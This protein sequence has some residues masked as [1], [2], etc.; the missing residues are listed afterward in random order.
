[1]IPA[2]GARR[3]VFAVTTVVVAA[4]LLVWLT[5]WLWQQDQVGADRANI[6][7]LPVAI[8]AALLAAV[9]TWFALKDRRPST[10]SIDVMHGL[11]R[12][13][14]KE[15]QRFIDQALGVHWYTDLADVT[16]ANPDAGKLPTGMETLLVNWQDV[17]G[18]RAG[19]VKDV[20]DFYRDETN[21]R[22]VILGPPGSG[23]SMVLSHLVCDLVDRLPE[24]ES[25]RPPH[26]WQVPIMISM[27]GCDLVD[28]GVVTDQ[29]LAERLNTW[30]AERLVDDYQIPLA[31]A[32]ALI[33]DQRILPVLDGLDEMDPDPSDNDPRLAPRPRAAAV[34]K[35]LNAERTPVVLACRDLEY[36][37]LIVDAGDGDAPSKPG[38]L[39][40]ARH[41]V[42]CPLPAQDVLDYLTDRFGS[43][44]KAL[45]NRWQPVADAL[46]AGEPLLRVLENPWQLF[47]A[48]KAYG[49]ETSN[50]A[51]LVTMTPDQANEQL[52]LALI[53]AVIDRDEIAA[54]N[55]WTADRVRHWL[56]S[57]AD[58]RYQSARVWDKSLT[59]VRLPDLWSVAGRFHP[60]W[61]T[62]VIG[63]APTVL[64]AL[65]S[66]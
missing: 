38:L 55:G 12:L 21:G 34:I 66:L 40:D 3:R 15:R 64:V 47:L 54:A 24:P 5:L 53:P 42:L 19:S 57:I 65:H 7:N 48:V 46:N 31:Q 20:A 45:P 39:T 32:K 59:E 30:I 23:K 2:R 14:R 17:D 37:G 10:S 50:P 25:D 4:F 61:I 62:E 18:K 56:T 35:A 26:G 28:P 58:H 49:N 63:V 6:L 22:L 29:P 1:V 33:S 27:P 13:V 43:R 8:V 11:M 60:D 41:V 52:L 44:T 16:F 36:K 9:P 51:E